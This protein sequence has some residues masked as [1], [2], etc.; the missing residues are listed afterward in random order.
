MANDHATSTGSATS[1]ATCAARARIASGDRADTTTGSTGRAVAGAGSGTAGACSTMTCALVP[2]IPKEDTA[3]RRGRPASGQS[4]GSA[5]SD[6]APAD[7]STCGLGSSACR[8][9]GNDPCRMA[10]TILITPATPAAAWVWPR[11]DFT[12][13]SHSGR[14]RSW[15]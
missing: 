3:A 6:T 2:L 11:F 13:P 10:C 15:P 8:V 14:S 4:A 9:R 12:E 1:D 5:S 7:Q